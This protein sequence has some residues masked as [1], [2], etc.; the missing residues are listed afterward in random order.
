MLNQKTGNT[1]NITGTI[2]QYW[3]SFKPKVSKQ[4]SSGS[5]D[6]TQAVNRC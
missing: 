4:Y 3:Q 1:K 2:Q 6:K 5:V